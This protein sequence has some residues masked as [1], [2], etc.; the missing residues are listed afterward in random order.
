[1]L[2]GGLLQ[3]ENE[4][5]FRDLARHPAGSARE[6]EAAAPLLLMLMLPLAVAVLVP[7]APIPQSERLRLSR[8]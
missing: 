3:R 2:T 4:P 6:T 5:Q 8:Y 7:S 1:M